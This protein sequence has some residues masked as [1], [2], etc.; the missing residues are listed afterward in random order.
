M[1]GYIKRTH[2]DQKAAKT[3]A[4]LAK[5]A[6]LEDGRVKG[7]GAAPAA[8]ALTVDAAAQPISVGSQ[9]PVKPLEVALEKGATGFKAK[10]I[11]SKNPF[12]LLFGA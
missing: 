10:P 4:K 6:A 8:N 3:A 11:K 2:A 5:L 12:E 1:L 9:A 7:D